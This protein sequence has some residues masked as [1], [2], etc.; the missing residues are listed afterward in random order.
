M[1]IH[2][3]ADEDDF[4]RIEARCSEVDREVTRRTGI[5]RQVSGGERTMP[6][7]VPTPAPMYADVR[8]PAPRP[9]GIP[10]WIWV[11]VALSLIHI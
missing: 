7:P 2:V 11:I 5:G 9:S 6:S 3:E 4:D 1:V 10:A 8:A